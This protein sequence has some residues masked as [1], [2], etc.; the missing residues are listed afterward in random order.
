MEAV[1]EV[2]EPIDADWHLEG[3]E[4]R[5][6]ASKLMMQFKRFMQERMTTP[7]IGMVIAVAWTF[8]HIC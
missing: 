3:S 7:H 1:P 5:A 4:E 2:P 6:F 8:L